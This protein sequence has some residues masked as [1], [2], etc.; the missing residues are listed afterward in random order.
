MTV[1]IAVF[2]PMPRASD[3]TA[4]DVNAGFLMSVRRPYLMSCVQVSM[5]AAWR[6]STCSKRDRQLTAIEQVRRLDGGEA[7][8]RTSGAQ[9]LRTISRTTAC[10]RWLTVR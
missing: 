3:N 2:A 6:Q 1:K 5:G 9:R 7:G 4:T 10:G 8:R